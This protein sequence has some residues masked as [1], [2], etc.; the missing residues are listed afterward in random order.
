M[1]KPNPQPVTSQQNSTP[2][3]AAAVAPASNATTE[4]RPAASAVVKPAVRNGVF[5]VHG[6][7]TDSRETLVR[8][9]ELFGLEPIVL[10]EQANRGQTVI[11]KVEAYGN[12]L[13]AIVLLTPDDVGCKAGGQLGPRPRQNVIAELGYFMGRLGRKRV[14]AFATSENMELPSDFAGIVWQ[15]FDSSGAW[16]VSLAR[17]FRASGLEVD[18]NKVKQAGASKIA[19]AEGLKTAGY[20]PDWNK[21]MESI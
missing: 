1:W 8:F 18:W 4:S 6:H 21:V 9:V 5:I 7:D 15:P 2:K 14:C 11:E 10:A 19:L 3:T 20:T 16:R 13:L 17:E 12:V